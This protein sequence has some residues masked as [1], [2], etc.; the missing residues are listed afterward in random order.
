MAKRKQ[1]VAS[2]AWSKEEVRLLK[3]AFRSTSTKAVAEELGRSV[4]S[5]QAK[6]S[7]LG[8]KKTRK[9]LKSIGKAK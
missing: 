5:V 3:K 8:L 1:K 9:Y 2:G 6:A 7:A 4:T